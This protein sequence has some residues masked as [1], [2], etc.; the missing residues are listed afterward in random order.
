[1]TLNPVYKETNVKGK[2]NE[3]K[4]YSQ[5]LLLSLS[6]KTRDGNGNKIGT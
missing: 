5:F 4:Q 2:K 6:W 1:M 3:D